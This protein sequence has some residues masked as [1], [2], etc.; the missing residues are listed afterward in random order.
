MIDQI[1][2][3]IALASEGTTSAAAAK[4]RVSQSTISKRITALEA[5]LGAELHERVGREC[6][7]TPY[8][9]ALIERAAPLLSE[10]RAVL[11]TSP[12]A[13]T[14]TLVI[15]C[16]ESV[17]ASWGARAFATVAEQENADGDLG[18]EFHTHR[19][20]LAVER[21]RAGRCHAALVAGEGRASSE[22]EIEVLG[23]EEMLVVPAALDRSVIRSDRRG[24][25]VDVWTIEEAASTW[26]SIASRIASMRRSGL[27]DLRVA[28]RLE[29][30][31]SLVQFAR[32]GF[33]HALV[34]RGVALAMGLQAKDLWRIRADRK[35]TPPLR[36]RIAWVTRKR[37][38]QLDVVRRVGRSLQ[39]E[40]SRALMRTT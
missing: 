23:Y 15:A 27:V 1:D 16:S 2:A 10:L 14:T 38:G 6:R 25:S 20:P 40:I 28:G 24:G 8:G 19:S 5:R 9:E 11:S 18:F 12:E 33:G 37:V 32:A 7:L 4:L 13:R 17:F 36:R 31:A 3:L 26:K 22:L 35:G 39:R 29:S 30:F 21:V 34:P